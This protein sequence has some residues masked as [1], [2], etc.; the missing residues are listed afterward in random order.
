[1][2][3]V[4][5]RHKVAYDLYIK[6]NSPLRRAARW[7]ISSARRRDLDTCVTR[8]VTLTRHNRHT[9]QT[10]MNLVEPSGSA[11]KANAFDSGHSCRRA[12]TRTLEIA[13]RGPKVWLGVA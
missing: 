13:F 5:Y 12:A 11:E 3:I 8:I 7:G 2:I 6:K 10:Y 4:P 9:Y 1:M